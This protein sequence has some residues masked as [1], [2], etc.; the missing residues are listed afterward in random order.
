MMW[1]MNSEKRFILCTGRKGLMNE[2][3]WKIHGMNRNKLSIE[4]IGISDS[5]DEQE[6]KIINWTG[7]KNH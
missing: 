1:L 2:Q 4:W 3:E 7:M 6:W 5:L